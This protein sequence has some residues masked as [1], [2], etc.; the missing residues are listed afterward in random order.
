MLHVEDGSSAGVGGHAGPWAPHEVVDCPLLQVFKVLVLIEIESV[1]GC[2][3]Y[4]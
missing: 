3:N 2:Y 1:K 4:V